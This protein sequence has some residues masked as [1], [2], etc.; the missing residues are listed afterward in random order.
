MPHR[1]GPVLAPW[2]QIVRQHAPGTPR[3]QEREEPMEHL[4][5][6]IGLRTPARFRRWPQMFHQIPCCLGQVGWGW[7][8]RVHAP[9]ATPS[10]VAK[11]SFLDTL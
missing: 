9:E 6:G 11:T 7:L 10:Q 1:P 4:A 5:L 2:G 3:P 8:S